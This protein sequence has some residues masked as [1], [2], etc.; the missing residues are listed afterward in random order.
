[1]RS[2]F[3]QASLVTKKASSLSEKGLTQ[4]PLDAHGAGFMICTTGCMTLEQHDWE[5]NS[6]LEALLVL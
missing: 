3:V 6:L 5:D 2:Y 4:R 1:M